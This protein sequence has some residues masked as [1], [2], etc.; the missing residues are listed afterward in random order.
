MDRYP[1]PLDSTRDT[2]LR[3]IAELVAA[4]G[5]SGVLALAFA[6][7]EVHPVGWVI[8]GGLI[9]VG[10]VMIAYD[11]RRLRRLD[12]RAWTTDQWDLLRENEYR[13]RQGVFLTHT[14]TPALGNSD[15][16]R[17]WWTVNVQLVQHR[18][19]PLSDD[20]I[21]EVEYSFGPQFTEG[22]V[23]AQSRQDSFG[24]ETKL[25]GP[26]LVLARVVFRNPFKRPL[27]VERYIDPP[28]R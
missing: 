7:G 5:V 2:G 25:H 26:L 9:V 1:S 4:A 16:D 19:G 6:A 10:G 18:T 15:D 27:L 14:A 17:N 20:K 21:K 13:R 12:A 3:R 11:E 24:H 23:K 28:R 8:T 22:P